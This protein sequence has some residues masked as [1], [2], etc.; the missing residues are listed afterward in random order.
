MTKNYETLLYSSE[1]RVVRITLD[2]PEKRN[3]LNNTMLTELVDAFET[4]DADDDAC[5][6]VLRGAG[7]K[8][9]CAG[10][11]LGAFSGGDSFYDNFESRGLFPKLFL[12]MEKLSKPTLAAVNGHCVAG[13]FGLM[14]A[15][16][17]A[18]AKSGF[19][20]GTPEIAR[21]LFPYMISALINR[22][23]PRRRV[24][25]MMLIGEL[26]TSDQAAEWDVVNKTV[27]AE[28]FDGAVEA[29]AS[30]IGGYSPAVIRLGRRA[31]VQK[32]GMPLE[33]ALSYLQGLLSVNVMMEDAAEGISA[34]FEKRD[35]VWKGK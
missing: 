30:K 13:G 8:A 33:G 25:E 31:L 1:E 12:T 29:W 34:F 28:E 17:L 3:A 2:R 32:E 10:A 22:S 21:G 19:K 26:F 7:D 11:D 6:V 9:F 18:I 35:P 20:M 24:F 4:A 27:P 15:C 5:V 23:V 14:M 16:D